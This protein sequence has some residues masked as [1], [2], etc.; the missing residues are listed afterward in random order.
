MTRSVAALLVGLG[1]GTGVAAA[2]EG[3]RFTVTPSFGA[4]RYDGTSALSSIKG[5]S[6]SGFVQL[7]PSMG[8]STMYEVTP[9]VEAGI[10]LEGGR[11]E[12]SSEYYPLVLLRTAGNYQL[13]GVSQRVVVLMYGLAANVKV[14]IVRKFGPYVHGGIGRHSVFPD[15]QR[16][17]TTRTVVGLE[18]V[19]GGGL[20]YAVSSS[21]GMR[22]ELL[23][24][25]W[26]DWDRDKLNPIKDPTQVNT[27]FAEDNPAGITAGK[28]SII[29][30]MRL[31]LGFTFTPSA[32]GTR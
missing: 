3:H 5:G 31:A 11:A 16:A 2:Q 8:L 4:I 27:V 29:H 14:P 18:F 24:F 12:T 25:L 20:N 32:G 28:P 17:G 6:I 30:N 13:F 1:V 26:K 15:V 22:L 21:I 7:W 10:Y 9:N 23:D 19:A